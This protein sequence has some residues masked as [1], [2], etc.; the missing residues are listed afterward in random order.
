MSAPSVLIAAGCPHATVTRYRC[1]HLQEQLA[2]NGIDA[3]VQEWYDLDRIDSQ[4]ALPDR[5]LVLQR[6]PMTQ[7]L[8]ALIDR[9]KAAGRPVIFDVDD[10]VFEPQLAP[11]HRGVANLSPAEQELYLDGVRRYA[12]TL[13]RCDHVLTASPLLAELA[14]RHGPQAHVLRNALGLE[15][16]AWADELHQ[17][18]QA[19]LDAQ[20]ADGRLVIGYGS[21]T[22]T[23]DVDFAEAAPA[24]LDILTRYAHAEL[25]IAGPMRLPEELARFGARVRRFPL[26]PWRE[27]FQLAAQ[28]D[29][30]LAPLEMHNLFCRA[31]SEI[32]FVEA[33]ALGLPVVASQI[34]PFAAAISEGENGFLAAN[35]AQWLAALDKLA[36]SAELRRRIGAAARQTVAGLYSPQARA[37]DL[38]QLLPSL[39]TQSGPRNQTS[40][41]QRMEPIEQSTP[42]PSG[43]Q[44][45]GEQPAPALAAAELA[46]QSHGG[47]EPFVP[48]TIHWLVTEPFAGSGGHIGI[49]R[50]IR[51][52]VDFGHICHVHTIPVNFMH[53][54]TPAQIEKYVNTHFMPTGAIFHQWSGEIGPAD[55]TVA[56]YWKTVPLLLKLPMPGRRYYLVQDFEPYFYAVGSEYIQAEN[57]YRQ[58]LHCLTLGPWLAKLMR[59]QYGAEAD[60]FDF[61]VDTDIYMPLPGPRP[62]HPRLAFY[63]RPS[64]PRRAYELGLEALHLVSKRAPQVEII[65]YGAQTLPPPP[66]PITNAGILNPWELAKLFSTCDVG[67]VFST[68]NPSFVPLEMMACRCAVVDLAS[69]R[70]VGLLEDGVNCR[71]AQPTP[72]SIADTV[73]DLLWD[74]ERRAAIVE[75]AF[76]QVEKMSW[77]RSAHQLEAAMLRNAPPPASRVAWRAAGSEDIDMLAWQ[78]HQLLDAG[79]D[80]T[81][82]IDALRDALY[83]TL[84]EKA[85]LVQ[86]VQQVEQQ[87]QARRRSSPAGSAQAALQ[88]LADR[89][90]DSAPGWLQGRAP[91]SK[92]ALPQEP[93]CQAF[94]A[95]RSHLRRVELRFAPRLPVHTGS[96][97]VALYEGDAGGRLVA[98][99]LLRVAELPLDAPC[100]VDFAPE[101]DSYG[102]QYVLCVAA[103]EVGGQPPAIWRFV[104]PQL[105]GAALHQGAQSLHGQIAIQPFYGEHPPLLP[106]RQGPA[107]WDAPVRLAPTVAREVVSQR[108]TALATLAGKARTALQQRGV[109][110]LGREVLNYVEWQLNGRSQE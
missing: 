105:A 87:Y 13:E 106:P 1:L 73:L 107:A 92:L 28:M 62:T 69:E 42:A 89:M 54:Y 26:L 30:A 4:M 57:T 100:T 24:V 52:L 56:T 72:E 21:G 83:R 49:F 45:A 9:M 48:L 84:A 38:A 64:T 10:L 25:W 110:G 71:L 79:G 8:A 98:S 96:I 19:R 95:D 78:I 94:S 20:G 68:T 65:F 2:A 15:M 31:K 85:T 22:A 23:H 77:R 33:G 36:A 14:A 70:V 11:W 39:L 41:E 74:R 43:T 59:E 63:A 76:Q 7:A 93:L 60:H 55:A 16:A 50:M 80:N 90:I 51:H 35:P 86:H 44:P 67:L 66:F 37:A 27:W 53:G 32:K 18:R 6:V 99:E 97:S 34:D 3:V 5:A 104:Q 58:G 29:I 40:V 91:L 75:T 82:V 17:L 46:A 102:K 103:V 101:V 88:P 81:A 61:A 47:D 108:A 109:A 12:K